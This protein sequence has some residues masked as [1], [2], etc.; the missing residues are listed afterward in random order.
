MVLPVLLKMANPYNGQHGCMSIQ[1]STHLVHASKS[2]W[3]IV[4]LETNT[5][6]NGLAPKYSQDIKESPCI[7]EAPDEDM[8]WLHGGFSFRKRLQ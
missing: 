3:S 5:I 8:T 7:V 1:V 4:P 6:S 2:L